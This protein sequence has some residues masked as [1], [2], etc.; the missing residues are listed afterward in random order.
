MWSCGCFH[1]LEYIY[2]VL[3]LFSHVRIY[4]CG[5]VVVF[6]CKNISMWSCGCFHM[7]EYIYVVLWL[8]A[9]VRIYLCGPVVVS[10]C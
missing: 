6:T 7:L 1:M 9:H 10:T 4:L 3:W 5:P 2:V 8:F